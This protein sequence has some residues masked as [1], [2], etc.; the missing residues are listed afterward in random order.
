[1]PPSPT[2]SATKAEIMDRVRAMAPRFSERAAA[3]EEAR[4]IP[5]ESVDEML[6]AGFARILVPK[7]VGGYGLGFDTWFEVDARIVQGRCLARLVR[8]PDHPP[9]SFDRAVSGRCAKDAVG[10]RSRRAGRRVVRTCDGGRT[11]RWRLSRLRKGLAV[12]QRRRSLHLGHAR[13]HGAGRRQTRVEILPGRAR[14]LHHSRYLVH[15]RHARHWQQ[16]HRYRQRFRAERAGAE[17]D[18]AARRHDAGRRHAQRRH[19]PHAIF[20][21]RADL[22][23]DADARRGARRL[24]AFPRLDQDAP[25]AGWFIGRRKNLGAGAHG[26][27]RRRS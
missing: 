16:D 17:A 11:G 13:W 8:Q 20:L 1:M 10:Q 12:R 3:A 27:R 4:R 5:Q 2:Q 24:R 15:R 25:G 21:L 23:C 7:S 22:V 18:G 19:L 6:D 14:G 9:Q 26:P